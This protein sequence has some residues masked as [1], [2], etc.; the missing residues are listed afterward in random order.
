MRLS[1]Q[2]SLSLCLDAMA[3]VVPGGN[4]SS[5]LARSASG[6]IA[7]HDPAVVGSDIDSSIN[8]KI[9]C[10]LQD[11]SPLMLVVVDPHP[12]ARLVG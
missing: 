12:S 11:E 6:W 10:D 8:T 5:S 4:R 7:V 2:A 9:A 1:F 3:V